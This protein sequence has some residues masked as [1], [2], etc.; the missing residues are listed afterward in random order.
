MHG[1]IPDPSHPLVFVN[2]YILKIVKAGFF[3]SEELLYIYLVLMKIFVLTLFFFSWN[4]SMKDKENL[5]C[6][7]V[8][9]ENL[10]LFCV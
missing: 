4:V 7:Y 8:H 10:T 3:I 5:E 6:F 9:L 1:T 2:F